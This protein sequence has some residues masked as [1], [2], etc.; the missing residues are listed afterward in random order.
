MEQL[1]LL[2]GTFIAATD[3]VLDKVVIQVC[4]DILDDVPA[5]DPRWSN[6]NEMG[7]GSSYSVQVLK[8]L[9]DKQK[10]L[11]IFFKF[12]NETQ[13]WNRLS[14]VSRYENVLCTVHVL[15]KLNLF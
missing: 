11:S 3:L 8:Q 15:G 4:E 10:A 9:E 12:L 13:L 1:F 5:S 7:L 6:T 2:E 14:A